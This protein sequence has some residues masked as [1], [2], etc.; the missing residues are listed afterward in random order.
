MPTNAGGIKNATL[1]KL[2]DGIISSVKLPDG[3]FPD[4][5]PN[6]WKS[7]T[8]QQIDADDTNQFV[9]H[10]RTNPDGETATAYI[11]PVGSKAQ[12]IVGIVDTNILAT[13]LV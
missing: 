8:G 5:P 1:Q 10:L 11:L 12:V 7:R 6:A 4:P 2:I 13:K 3:S 9:L